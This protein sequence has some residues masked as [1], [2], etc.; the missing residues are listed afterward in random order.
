[1]RVH[2]CG[3]S[4]HS[5][6]F[7]QQPLSLILNP[8]NGPKPSSRFFFCPWN[9]ELSRVSDTETVSE[10]LLSPREFPV[11]TVK[12]QQS[13]NNPPNALSVDWNYPDRLRLPQEGRIEQT[14]KTI[15][16]YTEHIGGLRLP[17]SLIQPTSNRHRR[18]RA[19]WH[20]NCFT[21]DILPQPT[22]SG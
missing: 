6:F 3:P 20:G 12:P 11:D 10:R 15:P 1:M 2:W 18:I 21:G 22:G 13:A 5:S 16:A 8:L 9:K 19:F 17:Y 4:M 7:M 14:H